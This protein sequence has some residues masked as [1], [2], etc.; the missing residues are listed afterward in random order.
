MPKNDHVFEPS[1]TLEDLERYLK[2]QRLRITIV[3]VRGS[4]AYGVNLLK[5]IDGVYVDV[6]FGNSK[7]LWSALNDAAHDY[8]NYKKG[9]RNG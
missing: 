3:K 2:K 8:E 6:A 9:L 4:R 7:H 1:S 5:P